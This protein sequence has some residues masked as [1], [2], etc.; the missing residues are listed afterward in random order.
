MRWNTWVPAVAGAVVAVAI[1]FG[2]SQGVENADAASRVTVTPE[3]LLINQRISQAGVRRSNQALQLLSPLITQPG[4]SAPAGWPTT[5]IANN[6]VTSAKIAQG[7]ITAQ[8]LAPQLQTQISNMFAVVAGAAPPG[9]TTI[10]RNSG[11]TGVTRVSAGVYS[12]TFSAPVAN[13][14]YVATPGDPGTASAVPP[15]ATA[16]SGLGGN[17]NGVIVKIA[18]ISGTSAGEPVDTSF[19]L[20]VIC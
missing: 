4:Q 16:V 19:H 11:A 14:A 17:P 20:A 15:L 6:A 12:V 3:Q 1:G 8:D 18:R 9:A 7:T 2:I 10:V 5:A 13:C